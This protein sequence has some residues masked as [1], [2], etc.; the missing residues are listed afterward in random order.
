MRRG[1]AAVAL[2]AAATYGAATQAAVYQTGFESPTY[3]TAALSGQDGW[4]TAVPSG[5]PWVTGTY[6]VEPGG[7]DTASPV[8]SGQS[9]SGQYAASVATTK[10]LYANRA[11]TAQTGTVYFGLTIRYDN[12]DSNDFFSIRLQ[13]SSAGTGDG[14]ALGFILNGGEIRTRIRTSANAD[15][16]TF[17]GQ[18]YSGSAIRI[19]GRVRAGVNG[20]GSDYDQISIELSPG[21]TEPVTYDLTQ[22]A[23]ATSTGI[24]SLDRFTFRSGSGSGFE[25]GDVLRFDNLVISDTYASVVPEPASLGALALAVVAGTRRRRQ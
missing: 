23:T 15:S 22:N 12:F 18:S 25:V 21:A 19:V 8:T 1:P 10:E 7:V 16:G 4:T 24:T 6:S 14:S 17:A 5:G 11:I 20:L 2:L 3:S 9:Q 13:N